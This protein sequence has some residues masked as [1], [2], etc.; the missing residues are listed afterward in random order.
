M[1]NVRGQSFEIVV[2][3]VR[4]GGPR[5]APDAPAPEFLGASHF[6]DCDATIIKDMARR[7]AAG[8]KDEWKRA[9]RIERWVKA[10]MRRGQR[11]RVRPGVSRWPA[12]CAATAGSTPC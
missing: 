11:R 5:L 6:L 8:E 9:Q 1:K 3:P 4:P 10:N 2:H 7:A 12:T